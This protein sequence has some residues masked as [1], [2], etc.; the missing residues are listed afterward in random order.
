MKQTKLKTNGITPNNNISFSIGT[1]LAVHKHYLKLGFN[2]V[3]SKHKKKE[4][5][6]VKLAIYGFVESYGCWLL[7]F[8]SLIDA[9]RT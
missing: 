8:L 1:I 3:F 9:R 5:K 6:S 4:V 2:C 7:I